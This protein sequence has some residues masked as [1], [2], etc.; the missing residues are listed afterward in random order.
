MGP[1]LGFD[2]AG[3]A[4]AVAIVRGGA[5]LAAAEEP[6][7][8]GHAERLLPLAETLLARAGL[9][10]RDLAAIGAGTGPG[11]FTGIRICVA[12]ARGLSLSLGVPAVGV[13][14]LEALAFDLPAP[15]VAVVAGRRD[16]LYAQ[17]FPADGAASAPIATEARSLAA[18]VPTGAVLVGD[19]AAE[20][21]GLTRA[22]VVAPAHARAVAIAHLAAARAGTAEGQPTPL[23]LRRPDATPVA[24][25]VRP[26]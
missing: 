26:A 1:V 17:T 23:Y 13:S 12:A 24:T 19:G 7:T 14:A 5:V 20:L 11:N 25:A 9:G 16:G 18:L 22:P 8:R 4:C 15:V 6:L 3:G 21:A 10:W 2:T